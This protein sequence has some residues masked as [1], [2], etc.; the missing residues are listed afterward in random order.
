MIKSAKRAIMAILNNADVKD[1]ELLTAFCGA[2]AL[3]NSRPLTYQS[4]NIKDNVPLTTN[5]FLHGQ[6]GGQFAPEV[7]DGIAHDPKK[8]WRRVQELIRH[9]WHRWLKEWIPSLSP[10][11]KLMKVKKNINPGDVVLVV[12]PQ[13]TKGSMAIG[14]N[15][16]SVSWKGWICTISQTTS[17]RQAV[18]KTDC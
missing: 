7:V 5:H 14:K 15:T 16:R 4:A 3:I 17:W 9:F 2:E 11:Q 13:N 12:S 18:F 8:H 1:E 10:Q 6:M